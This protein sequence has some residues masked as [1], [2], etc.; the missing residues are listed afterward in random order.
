MRTSSKA[1][2]LGGG[3]VLAAW[4][5]WGLYSIRS[6]ESIQYERIRALDGVELRRYP[7]TV[8]VETTAPDQITAFRRL[9]RYISGANERT[10]SIAMTAPVATNGG[11][12][13]SMTAPV[14]SGSDGDGDTYR[15]AFY[16][17]EE[18]RLETAPAPTDPTVRLVGEPPRRLA[19]TRFS[20]YA[21]GWRVERRERSLLT[22][23]DDAGVETRGEPFLL[24][25]NDPWT[26]PFLR[27]NE[28]AVEVIDRGS[29][30]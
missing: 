1:A 7:A 30:G 16:L 15:M 18:Y 13:L 28:V 23:L 12:T 11:E 22:T 8:R 29:T 4:T 14:R 25:Y 21:P 10:A 27:R 20:W 6:A 24:R 26:P 5:A 3:A 9:F 2:I 17:P 19:V